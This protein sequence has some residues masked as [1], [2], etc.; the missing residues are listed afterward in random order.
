MARTDHHHAP[1]GGSTLF[2]DAHLLEQPGRRASG[3][4]TITAQVTNEEFKSGEAT[5]SVTVSD[6][7][8]QSPAAD[9]NLSEPGATGGDTVSLGGQFTDPAV[10]GGTPSQST[11]ATDPRPPSSSSSSARSPYRPRRASIPIQQRI[12]I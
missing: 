12:N 6:V 8:P 5:A 11:G 2:D 10:F 1:A 3:N 4:Y 7:A 9:L